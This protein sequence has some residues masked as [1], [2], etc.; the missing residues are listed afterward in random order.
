MTM[1]LNAIGLQWGSK[2]HKIQPPVSGAAFVQNGVAFGHC[3]VGAGTYKL[4][5]F[6]LPIY[7]TA[8]GSA[9]LT[10]AAGS[11]VATLLSGDTKLMVPTTDTAWTVVSGSASGVA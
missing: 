7:V 1:A 9:T 4:P 8:T 6:G 2:N 10:N 11:A 5:D 3:E